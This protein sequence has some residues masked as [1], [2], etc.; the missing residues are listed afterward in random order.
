MIPKELSIVLVVMS[1]HYEI[2]GGFDINISKN[3]II[4]FF[5]TKAIY[6]FFNI[7]MFKKNYDF[8]YNHELCIIL[9]KIDYH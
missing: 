6:W 9:V 8:N 3:V 7:I 2:S 1:M 5:F 4:V